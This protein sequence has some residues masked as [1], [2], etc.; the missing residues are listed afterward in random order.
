[1]PGSKTYTSNKINELLEMEF[2]DGMSKMEKHSVKKL[3][4]AF[5]CEVLKINL[6]L[7]M[8]AVVDFP[9]LAE[10][11]AKAQQAAEPMDEHI[12]K[13]K[14]VIL[15]IVAFIFSYLFIQLLF[16]IGRWLF[17]AVFNKRFLPSEKGHAYVEFH[18][19]ILNH[20]YLAIS[21]ENKYDMYIFQAAG[22]T[23][24]I[25]VDLAANYL[26]QA[27]HYFKLAKDELYELIP[28]DANKHSYFEKR[29][30]K[31]LNYIGFPIIKIALISG[32]RSLRRLLETKA[33][34]LAII[35]SNR[36]DNGEHCCLCFQ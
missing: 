34:M 10:F 32:Q 6:S 15:M 18:K 30:A 26:S 12:V 33:T 21:F 3:S 1:M 7:L 16:V 20:I 8:S 31:Y 28:P 36:I 17:S 11:L 24:K 35:D 2:L 14:T 27:V 4:G 5:F 23:T 29:N 19:K 9:S 22:Q 13:I 25:A